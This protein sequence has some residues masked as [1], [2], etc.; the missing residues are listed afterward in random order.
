MY[1]YADDGVRERAFSTQ[2]TSMTRYVVDRNNPTGYA[3]TLE[4][5][6]GSGGAGSLARSYVIGN[7]VIAQADINAAGNRGRRRGA[8]YLLADGH[9]STRQVVSAAGA[10]EQTVAYDAYGV[11]RVVT[12]PAEPLTAILYAA[13]RT[14]WTTKLQPLGGGIRDYEAGTGTLTTQDPL[15]GS[16]SDPLSLHKYAYCQGNPVMGIDP[17]GMFF[18]CDAM[19]SASIQ[20]M[21]AGIQSSVYST[22]FDAAR[23]AASGASVNSMLMSLGVANAALIF[24]GPILKFAA[25]ALGSVAKL[26]MNAVQVA[27]R[28]IARVRTAAGMV[29]VFPG[30]MLSAQTALREGFTAGGISS[31]LK[32]NLLEANGL[33]RTL[34]TPGFQAHHLIPSFLREHPLLKA[35]GFDF[36][37]ASN[38][39][40]LSET[41]HLGSHGPYSE[42]VEAALDR[43]PTAWSAQ[44][45]AAAVY[46]IQARAGIRLLENRAINANAGGTYQEW[47]QWLT[48]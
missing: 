32:A 10:V 43:I 14:D 1:W 38:G 22:A 35:I 24:A 5:W 42:A 40:L 39:I 2:G 25:K 23:E 27:M 20:N 44:Q 15:P 36:D 37:Q 19:I 46:D 17:T 21:L 45:K 8:R 34:P 28:N 4:E 18:M 41:L 29:D 30:F 3:Q 16:S 11:T 33:A 31:I 47:L 12:G 6:V 26:S 7:D 9:G 48:T 13:G